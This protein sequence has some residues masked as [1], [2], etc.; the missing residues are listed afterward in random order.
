MSPGTIR[1]LKVPVFL[2]CLVPAGMLLLEAFGVAGLSLGANPVEAL[3]HSLGTWSLNF[4]L[5]TL[6]VTPLRRL[7]GQAW[8]LRFR[9]MFG[10]FAFFYLLLHF[11]A[12]AGVDQRFAL[13]YILEDIAERPYITLGFAAFLLLIPLAATSTRGMIRRLGPRW[14]Q[15]HRLVYPAAILGVWHYYWLVKADVLQPL[16]YAALLILLLALRLRKP[17]PKRVRNRSLT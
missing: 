13:G 5:I 3:I 2:V 16:I 10:L 12:Y 4:L 17:T 6:A 7:T 8:L 9:R 11:L 15:L 14:K 1:W